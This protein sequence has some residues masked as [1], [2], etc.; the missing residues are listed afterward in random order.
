MLDNLLLNI[1]ILYNPEI[2]FCDKKGNSLC[3]YLA[4][5]FNIPIKFELDKD[6]RVLIVK[7]NKI[8]INDERLR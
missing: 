2:I 1:K 6:K 8:F 3:L 7:G 5:F 4:N